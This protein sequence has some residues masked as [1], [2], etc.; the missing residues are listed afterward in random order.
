M[1]IPLHL[2]SHLTPIL[3]D[4][5]NIHGSSNNVLEREL[6]LGIKRD[7][8]ARILPPN[9]RVPPRKSII[10]YIGTVYAHTGSLKTAINSWFNP[11][12]WTSSGGSFK[13][14]ADNGFNFDEI[15]YDV[16]TEFGSAKFLEIGAG[17][18]GFHSHDLSNS[19]SIKKLYDSLRVDQGLDIT[20]HFTNLTRWHRDLPDGVFE[21]PGVVGS[22]VSILSEIC[23]EIDVVYSQCAVYF[24]PN[25]VSFVEQI[26]KL[27]RHSR[28]GGLVIFN[29]KTE[30]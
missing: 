11:G 13:L 29:A 3:S 26:E 1:I 24:D 18:A 8:Q 25:V 19:D 28:K 6:L 23:E 7:V 21:H 17:Y 30:T 9:V 16:C 22:T 15:L 10:D 12:S 14:A 20:F 2:E 4:Y 5:V 27:M